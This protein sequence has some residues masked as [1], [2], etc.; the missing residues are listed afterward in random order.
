LE[1]KLTNNSL[2]NEKLKYKFASNF[3]LTNFGIR[4]AQDKI[5]NDNYISLQDVLKMLRE[6]P[7]TSKK[8]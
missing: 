4:Y 2:T 5:I 8:D 6:L 7:D 1:N 3:D